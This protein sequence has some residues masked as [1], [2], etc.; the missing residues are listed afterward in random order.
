MNPKKK[1]KFIRQSGTYLKRLKSWRRPR[2][3]QSKLRMH[4]KSKGHMP[5]PGYGSPNA[6]RGLHP[7]GYEEVLI[8][9]VK[10]LEQINKEKQAARISSR[11]GRR[12]R[13]DI[14]KTAKELNIK[15]LNPFKIEE[16]KENV[17]GNG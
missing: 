15:I 6:L 4:R 5:S 11:V 1:P 3:N 16:A 8:F 7:S 13:I 12:K 10:D 14:M 9:N 17:H 2:G